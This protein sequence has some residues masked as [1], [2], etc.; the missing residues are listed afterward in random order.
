MREAFP[1]VCA[2][3]VGCSSGGSETSSSSNG[4]TTTGIDAKCA[5]G[6][7]SLVEGTLD[8]KA[9]SVT[10][11]T[12]NWSWINFG[13]PSKFDGTFEGGAIHLEWGG[14]T[15][16]NALTTVTGANLV[17]DGDAATRTFQSGSLIYDSPD[18]ESI[19]KAKLTFDTGSVTV[20]MRK[21][22]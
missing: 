19:L 3:I 12:R 6:D 2:V 14:T 21:T 1:F 11:T 7:S 15:A 4:G 18:P 22:D 20:C 9:V 8:G 17:L 16:N 13:T 5:D 10:G